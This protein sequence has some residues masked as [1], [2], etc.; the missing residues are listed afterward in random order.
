MEPTDIRA[1]V[2][3]SREVTHAGCNLAAVAALIAKTRPEARAEFQR[4]SEASTVAARHAFE[5]D[6]IYRRADGTPEGLDAAEDAL[7]AAL[8]AIHAACEAIRAARA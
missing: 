8:D 6:D 7:V 3:A 1:V 5:L 4:A 2:V